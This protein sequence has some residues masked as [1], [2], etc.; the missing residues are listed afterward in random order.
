MVRLA[1]GD[2]VKG[3][4]LTAFVARLIRLRLRHPT[5]RAAAF[6]RR[7]NEVLPGVAPVAW[8]TEGG[9]E[10][11]DEDWDFA[12]G[13]LLML[14]RALPRTTGHPDVSLLLING[15]TDT[16]TFTMPAPTLRWRIRIDTGRPGA[17]ERALDGD[18]LEVI[19]PS[20]VL[21][22]C[23]PRKNSV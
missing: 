11:S 21:L 7:T 3:R 9:Q 2:S 8:F 10:M 23:T 14:R 4:A 12:D 6:M 20:V 18:S 13:R 5:L 19:G 15:T 22:T 16:H 1:V 17:A